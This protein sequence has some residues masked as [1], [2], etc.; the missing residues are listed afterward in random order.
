MERKSKTTITEVIGDT[1]INVGDIEQDIN[2][3]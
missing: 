1:P 2:K 3:I